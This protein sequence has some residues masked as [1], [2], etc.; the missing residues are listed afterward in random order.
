ME[1]VN[2]NEDDADTLATLKGIGKDRAL[3]IIEYRGAK[4]PL[5]KTGRSYEG[6]GDRAE[7]I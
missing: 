1:Q 4:R 6:E 7:D 2:I 5:P 3:K